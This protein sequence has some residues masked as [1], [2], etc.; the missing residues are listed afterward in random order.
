MFAVI[1]L[2]DLFQLESE[3]SL[4]RHPP[5]E[6]ERLIVHELYLTTKSYE[7]GKLPENAHWMYVY[8]Y[9]KQ[10]H[11]AKLLLIHLINSL[12]YLINMLLFST[13][14]L[15]MDGYPR[16]SSLALDNHLWHIYMIYYILQ[17]L[18]SSFRMTNWPSSLFLIFKCIQE[19]MFV[20]K[21][22]SNNV[23]DLS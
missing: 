16:F 1:L 11:I 2:C 6:D 12:F 21:R 22:A 5:T 10:L 17:H 7:N 4:F 3:Q 20:V 9:P 15:S 19:A 14:I 18:V 13:P 8:L 23:I